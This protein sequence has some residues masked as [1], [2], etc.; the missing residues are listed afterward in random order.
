MNGFLSIHIQS[1]LETRSYIHVSQPT[2]LS[3]FLLTH[4]LPNFLF[5]YPPSNLSSNPVPFAFPIIWTQHM[6][7]SYEHISD[8]HPILCHSSYIYNLSYSTIFNKQTMHFHI[9]LNDTYEGWQ[10]WI[11]ASTLPTHILAP[12]SPCNTDVL[13]VRRRSRHMPVLCRRRRRWMSLPPALHLHC[14]IGTDIRM[15]CEEFE[16]DCGGTC[17]DPEGDSQRR[18][19]SWS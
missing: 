12:Q 13:S 11:Q 2:N 18:S 10:Y 6:N 7:T 9:Y 5:F 4:T 16:C 17:H 15:H 14:G 8:L 19:W 3:A 1:Y